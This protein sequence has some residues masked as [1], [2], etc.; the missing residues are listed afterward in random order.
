METLAFY[1]QAHGRSRRLASVR[2]LRRKTAILFHLALALERRVIQFRDSLL[3]LPVRK[4][5]FR[6]E[7]RAGRGLG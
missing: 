2:G 1:D 5:A 6:M 3:D 7:S 4:L